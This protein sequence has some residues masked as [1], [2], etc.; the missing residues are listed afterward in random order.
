M[1]GDVEISLQP[2]KEEIDNIVE[3][4][5]SDNDG[6]DNAKVE[7]YSEDAEIASDKKEEL[8][9][10]DT[11]IALHQVERSVS[12]EE[13][14]QQENADDEELTEQKIMKGNA[15]LTAKQR[16]QLKKRG[17]FGDGDDVQ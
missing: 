16:R 11:S 7:Q 8:A 6:N 5:K 10:P 1:G 4:S 3:T 13:Q 14:K 15:R 2:I 17:K 9:F 12:Q